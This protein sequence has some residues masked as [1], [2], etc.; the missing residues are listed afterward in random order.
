[1]PT[2]KPQRVSKR[3]KQ[4]RAGKNQQPSSLTKVAIPPIPS[5]V[6]FWTRQRKAFQD[7]P[8]GYLVSLIALLKGAYELYEKLN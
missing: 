4:K 8:I 1:M 7:N 5:Q 6:D 3:G 2:S